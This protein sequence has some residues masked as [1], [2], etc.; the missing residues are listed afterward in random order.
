MAHHCVLYSGAGAGC[1][2]VRHGCGGVTR[3]PWCPDHGTAADR[4]TED[5]IE[6]GIDG[7]ARGFRVDDPHLVLAEGPAGVDCL[8]GWAADEDADALA[9]LT[10]GTSGATVF[11]LTAPGTGPLAV[12]GEARLTERFRSGSGGLR[13]RVEWPARLRGAARSVRLAGW[14]GTGSRTRPGARPACAAGSTAAGWAWWPG[15]ESTGLRPL[16]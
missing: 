9:A 11:R 15:A 13:I 16:R 6:G 3:R 4:V 12:L 10:A 2:C 7:A 14:S 8:S 1:G 5:H